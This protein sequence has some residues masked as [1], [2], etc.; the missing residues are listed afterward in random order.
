MDGTAKGGVAMTIINKYK[1]PILFL[2]VGEGIND[3][4]PFD[5]DSYISS[6]VSL[7]KESSN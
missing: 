1:V 2:G 7:K 6:L 3:F 5:L 4:I